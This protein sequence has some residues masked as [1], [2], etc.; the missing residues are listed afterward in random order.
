[1]TSRARRSATLLG[2]ALLHGWVALAAW[3]LQVPATL[4]FPEVLQVALAPELPARPPPERALAAP[5]IDPPRVFVPMPAIDLGGGPGITVTVAPP[6]AAVTPAPVSASSAAPVALGSE[7]S[8][9]C[10]ERSAPR[11]PA[12]A[13]RLRE[14]GSV[15]LRVLLDPEGRVAEVQ[16]AQSSRSR[17]LDEAAVAAVRS[18]RCTPASRDGVAVP[19]VALQ[20]FDFELRSRKN[21]QATKEPS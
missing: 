1:M 5:R 17:T 20:P 4:Q 21:Q 6:V 19:A 16:I 14:T 3:H 18:W 12:E 11:Y 15:L 7:L 8:L 13:R 2:I 10:P 9:A